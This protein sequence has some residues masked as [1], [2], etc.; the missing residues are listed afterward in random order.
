M[1]PVAG[2]GRR[3]V[4]ITAQLLRRPVELRALAP[5]LSAFLFSSFLFSS[6]C[7]SG[8]SPD[9]TVFPAA[10]RYQ[11]VLGEDVKAAE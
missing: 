1:Q 10:P 2:R 8:S 7:S 4:D 11:H 3:C 5:C 6:F 9:S